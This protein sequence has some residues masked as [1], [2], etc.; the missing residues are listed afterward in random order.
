MFEHA[1]VQDQDSS[2]LSTPKRIL[3]H[4]RSL[5]LVHSLGFEVI[6]VN[7]FLGFEVLEE[8]HLLEY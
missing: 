3:D 5:A 8:D 4:V 7:H 1:L 2:F 6:E